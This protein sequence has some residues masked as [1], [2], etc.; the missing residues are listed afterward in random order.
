[1]C[2]FLL[3]GTRIDHPEAYSPIFLSTTFALSYGLSFAAIAALIVHTV[4]FHGQEILIMAS[5]TRA[6]LDDIHMKMMKKYN[7]VTW[8]WFMILLLIT[9]GFCFATDLAWPTQLTWS[10]LALALIIPLVWTIAIDID[11]C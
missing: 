6:G 10:A 9:F 7:G 1:M 2:R 5:A 3:P 8:W 11:Q 4:I